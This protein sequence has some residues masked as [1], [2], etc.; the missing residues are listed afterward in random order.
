[1]ASTGSTNWQIRSRYGPRDSAAVLTQATPHRQRASLLAVAGSADSPP[2]C[3]AD[4]ANAD[5][6]QPP[7]WVNSGEYEAARYRVEEDALKEKAFQRDTT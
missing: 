4:P 6:E 5:A 7:Q 3:V 2:R 1:M